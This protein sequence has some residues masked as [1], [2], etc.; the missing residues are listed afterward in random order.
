MLI[1]YRDCNN[2]ILED[3]YNPMVFP[4]AVVEIISIRLELHSGKSEF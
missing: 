3:T 2:F 4:G 1:P